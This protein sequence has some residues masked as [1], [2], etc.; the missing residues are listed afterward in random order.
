MNIALIRPPK[1]TGAFEKILIQE[2][3]NLAYLAAFLNANKFKTI[4]WDFEVEH[5]SPDI[6]ARK[7]KEA[8]ISIIGIT[9]MTPTINNA[10]DLAKATKKINNNIITIAGGAH[11]SAVPKQ[12]LEEFPCFDYLVLREGEIALL[13]LCQNLRDKQPIDSISGIAFIK[14]EQAVINQPTEDIED[15]DSLPF[16]DRSLL[17]HN[18]YKNMYAAGID[19]AGKKP[20]VLFTSRGCSQDCTFCAVKKT[21]GPKARFRSAENVIAELKQCKDMG[22]NHITFEDTNLTLNPDRFKQIC[23]GLK[24]LKLTW[25]CQTKV[26]MVNKQLISLMKDCG[27]LKIAYGVESG[28]PKIL[29]LMKKNITIEQIKQAFKLTHKAGIVACAFFIL[30]SHPE[31]TA[32]DIALTEQIIK[33]IKPDVF[34]LGIICPYPGTEIYNIMQEYGLIKDIDWNKF[35]FMHSVPP[36]GTKHLTAQQLVTFQKQIYTRYLFSWHFIGFFCKKMLNP[37]QLPQLCKLSFYMLKYLLFEKR[38]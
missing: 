27:C 18:L 30:G 4:I 35:N 36:W 32:E 16:P 33:E 17:N 8:N 15:L 19:T 37:K 12:S 24:E 3:I 25:D 11:V 2:P 34:Q 20:T 9:S 7:I 5:F 23:F 1:I 38:K 21:S 10:H 6:L 13:K 29:K 28:S 22:Y 14:D 26:S 31:E